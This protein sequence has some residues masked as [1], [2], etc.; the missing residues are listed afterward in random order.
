MHFH[1]VV[2]F[3]A[4]VH[5]HIVVHFHAM[6]SFHVVVHFHAMISSHVVVHFH[7]V[8]ISIHSKAVVLLAVFLTADGESDTAGD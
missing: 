5:F 8:Y 6:I 7:A 4:V 1:I 3:H 2:H